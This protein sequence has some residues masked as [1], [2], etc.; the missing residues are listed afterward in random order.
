MNVSP[1]V[2]LLSII[3]FI[4]LYTVFKYLS[5]LDCVQTLKLQIAK[6]NLN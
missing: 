2:E 5:F 3:I 4:L 1:N 6:R